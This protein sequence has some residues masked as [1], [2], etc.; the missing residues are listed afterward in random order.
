MSNNIHTKLL[1]IQQGLVV[2]KE[3]KNTHMK[4]MFRSAE[5]ILEAVKPLL[6][7]VGMT[8]IISDKITVIGDRHYVTSTATLTDCSTGQAIEC[9]ASAR[10]AEEKRGLDVSQ[11]TGSTS[12]YARK[13]CLNGMFALDNTKDADTMDNSYYQSMELIERFAKFNEDP[14]LEG[15]RNDIKD[16]WRKCSSDA[17]SEVVLSRMKKTIEASVKIGEAKK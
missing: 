3:Q 6:K 8:L 5:D 2:P 16:A 15:K 9:T 10:E 13:Y 17:E 7:N 11:V 4:Y 12:S 1:A 14:A